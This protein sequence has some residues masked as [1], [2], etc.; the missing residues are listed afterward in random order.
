MHDTSREKMVA[1]VSTY[2]PSV[3]ATPLEILD[4][5]SRVVDDGHSQF[6]ELL[7]RPP[8]HYRGLDV[9]A[10]KNVDVVVRDP[11]RWDEL[12]A[13][14]VDLVVSGQ[15]LEHIRYFW[16]TAFEIGRVLRPGGLAFLI[17]PSRGFEH[18][19]PVDCWRF[20]RDGMETL[21]SYLGFTLIDSFTDWDRSFWADSLVVMEKPVWSDDER[22]AFLRRRELQQAAL[23]QTEVAAIE[24]PAPVSP[25]PL[26][27]AVPGLLFPKLEPIRQRDLADFAASEA[28]KAKAAR[29]LAE[30]ELGALLGELRRRLFGGRRSNAS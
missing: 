27:G 21:A 22:R 19:H 24:T 28:A 6:R 16:V 5:G 14:S 30:Q 4:V 10:G 17:A 20:Y 7:A 9:E 13:D 12:P 29:P 2:L 18:R 15:A 25:S 23:R 8:W 26:R 1:F 3:H 11:Y